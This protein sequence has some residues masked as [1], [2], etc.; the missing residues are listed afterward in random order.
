MMMHNRVWEDHSL[1]LFTP[2]MRLSPGEGAV[3]SNVPKNLNQWVTTLIFNCP[4]GFLQGFV[5]VCVIQICLYLQQKKACRMRNVEF[6]GF[7]SVS[8]PDQGEMWKLS[9]R[10]EGSLGQIHSSKFVSSVLE[11]L[12]LFRVKLCKT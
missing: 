9:W 12:H 4:F 5:F 11:I 10:R 6:R 8:T 2:R 3:M 1:L 7:E